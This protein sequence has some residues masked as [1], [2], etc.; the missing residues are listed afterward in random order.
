MNQTIQQ[1]DIFIEHSQQ[2]SYFTI[3]FEMHEEA[4]RSPCAIRIP[5]TRRTL[6]WATP[7]SPASRS[8]S[9]TWD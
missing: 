5:D 9:L 7:L 1:F 2:G 6:I 3:P 4:N 8:T